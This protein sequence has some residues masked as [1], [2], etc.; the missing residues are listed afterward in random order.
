MCDVVIVKLDSIVTVLWYFAPTVLWY[1]AQG[2][3]EL[4]TETGMLPL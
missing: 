1:P 2:T 3:K 4:A